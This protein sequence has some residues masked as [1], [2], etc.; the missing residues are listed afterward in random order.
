ML[1][2]LLTE[3]IAKQVKDVFDQTLQNS[4]HVLFFGS[5]LRCEYCQPTRSL[6]EEIIPLSDKLSLE[7]YDVE[8][9]PEI[10]KKYH[11]DKTPGIVI[12]AKEKNEII[13]YGIRYSGMPSG[14][15]FTSL[16]NDLIM[17]SQR[18]T[19]LNPDTRAYLGTINKDILLQVFVTPT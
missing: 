9:E 16:I 4:V 15:E 2:R 8:N 7:I 12:T 6:L 1:E 3:D 13:D 14:H 18:S 17:V 10:A 5:E 11:V 19:D